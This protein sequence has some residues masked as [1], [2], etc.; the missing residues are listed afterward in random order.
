VRVVACPE[1]SGWTGYTADDKAVL[2]FVTNEGIGIFGGASALKR[3][4]AALA[5]AGYVLELIPTERTGDPPVPAGGP[6]RHR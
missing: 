1:G 6:G 4:R 3:T 5:A 2:A